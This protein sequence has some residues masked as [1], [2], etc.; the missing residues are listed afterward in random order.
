MFIL[1]I[2]VSDLSKPCDI[3]PEGLIVGDDPGGALTQTGTRIR[4][5]NTFFRFLF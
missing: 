2:W 5:T 1:F 3:I 4:F